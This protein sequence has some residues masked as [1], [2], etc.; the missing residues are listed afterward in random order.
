M[1]T[2]PGN[3]LSMLLG[4]WLLSLP[5]LSGMA[6]VGVLAHVDKRVHASAEQ[7]Q[8][9]PLKAA[10][11]LLQ[12]KFR[13]SL[14]Y[15]RKSVEGVYISAGAM[16]VAADIEKCLNQLLPAYNLTYR[17]MN[18]DSYLIL[19]K[20][21]AEKAAPALKSE[22]EIFQQVVDK[23]ITG[24]VTDEKGESLAGVSVLVKGTLKGTNT[25]ADGNFRIS[26]EP[27]DNVL[28]FSFVGYIRQEVEV[29]N[30][31]VIAV[32]LKVETQT[33]SDV[34]VTALGFNRDKAALSY[35]VTE[36]G[37]DNLIKAR[38]T[39]LGNALVGRIA[40]VNATGLATGPGG[41]SRVVIRGNGSLNGN[42]QPLYVVN[43]VP[44][45]NNNQ[46]APGT[47]GGIDR[48]DGLTS[49]NP[50]DIATITVLKGGTAAAL[51][52]ARAANG[53]ILITTKSGNIQKGIGV[54]YNTTLTVETP[55]DL[56]DWQYEYGSGSRGKAPTSQAEA[57]AFGRMSWGAKLD[58]SPVV[59]P[60]GQI[61]PYEAQKN[62]IRNFYNNGTTF[63][64]TLAFSGGNEAVRFRFSAANMDNKGI[65]PNN[66]LNRKTF[67]LSANANLAKKLLF[68]GN[69][70][71]TLEENKNRVHTADFTKNPNAATQLIATNIDVRTLA[72]GYT[73]NGTEVIWSDYIYATNPYFAVDKVRNSDTRRR[74]IGSFN[75]RYN[76]TDWLYGRVR[77]GMDQLNFDAYNIEPSGIAFNDR[78]SMTTDLSIA[79]ETNAEAL[80]GLNKAFG[81]INVNALVGGNQMHNKVDGRTLSSGLFNV[82][83]QYFIGNGSG[84]NFTVNYQ[85]FAINSLFVSADIDYNNTLFFTFT[86][87]QDWFS[88]LSKENNNLFYPSVGL[89]YVLT[90]HWESHP[91][92]LDYAKVRTSWAQVGGGAPNPY[93]LTLTYTPQAQQHL[94]ATL[95]NVT[96]NVIPNKLVPYTSTTTEIGVDLKAF[97]NLVGVDLTFY[98]RST[99][100]DIVFASVPFSSGYARTALN[101]G[102]VRNR[103]VELLL[104][105]TLFRKA[106]WSW[107]ISYNA[108][109][110]NN[111]VVKIADGI[112]SLFIDGAT[113]RTQNGGIYHFEGRPF[114]MIAGNRPRVDANGRTVYNSANGIPVQGPLEPL[115]LGV[116][117]WIMGINN[118]LNY[119]NF[120]LDLLIDGKFGGQIYS[121]TNAYGTQF[122]L[123]RRTVEN[124]V[125]ESG[126]AVSGVDQRGAEYSAT[127]PAQTYYS[128]IWATLTDQ[129]VSSADFVK[130]RSLTFS[131]T[132]PKRLFAKTPI[133]SASLSV[134]GRNLALLYN[135]AR[136]I[137]PE[138][139]YSNG[140]GQG[141]ENFGLPSTRSFGMNLLVSF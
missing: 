75:A 70:Q 132:I 96:G 112:T 58:G 137:D 100:N 63:S 123:D 97:R 122:G 44:I 28:V 66:S 90:N 110:N 95:M 120:S 32:T 109:Y 35:A 40:G 56:L 117:P 51:Y 47:F 18:A 79:T 25:D 7:P 94:G 71:Y 99:T 134:V 65:V 55:R 8:S 103:G 30:Q 118:R 21:K 81:K 39:N 49:I 67:S 43:G 141:L 53:V 31:S 78:G 140:N 87:R 48:G 84:Q 113:T 57:I 83:F 101:V 61:R 3:K 59:Q 128:A 130:L 33:L 114:G 36:I 15:E 20:P 86:G 136:N 92:W 46:G 73:A 41:S 121:A 37:G 111:K 74:F 68:E 42:N 62:N 89:S 34:V 19:P 124:G 13:V 1:H 11:D 85:E 14:M 88:T 17:K 6:Q 104:T 106:N 29:G 24:K 16:P 107:D 93:G 108:A 64:N 80:I 38:E 102:Q 129:F 22:L 139:G 115:G 116:P 5:N 50:D 105:G 54:E 76:I 12:N 9:I 27:A 125:R 133:Q 91:T 131:Y 2:F 119:R 60:D 135:A 82:P 26:L 10:L 126:I 69:V 72:P 127:V 23:T 52:G 77:L 4:C 45:N 138:S 98:E